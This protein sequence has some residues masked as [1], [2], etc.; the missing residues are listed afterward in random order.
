MRRIVPKKLKSSSANKKG[1][2]AA[3]PDTVQPDAD[4]RSVD[5]ELLTPFELLVSPLDV[6]TANEVVKAPTVTVVV[7]VPSGLPGLC[8]IIIRRSPFRTVVGV[9]AKPPSFNT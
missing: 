1:S 9:L 3:R 5:C 8:V 2:N 6:V 7:L 4:A